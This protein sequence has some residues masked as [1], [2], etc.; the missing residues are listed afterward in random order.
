[1]VIIKVFFWK[2]ENIETRSLMFPLKIK[3]ADS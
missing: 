1:M 2:L 3:I